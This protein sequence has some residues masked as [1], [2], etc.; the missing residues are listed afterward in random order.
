MDDSYRPRFGEDFAF[1]S[2]RELSVRPSPDYMADPN[3]GV[4]ECIVTEEV[5]ALIEAHPDYHIMTC[6]EYVDA[7]NSF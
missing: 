2:W 7:A 5:L 6:E 3:V 1:I 4:L